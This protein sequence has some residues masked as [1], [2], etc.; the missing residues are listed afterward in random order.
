MA[1]VLGW[2]SRELEMGD[3]SQLIPLSISYKQ[4]SPTN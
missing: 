2:E 3:S 1:E 4:P